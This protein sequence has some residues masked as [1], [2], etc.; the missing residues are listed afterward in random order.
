MAH[1]RSG[2]V[3]VLLV[4]A[5]LQAACRAGV[6]SPAP[7]SSPAPTR[8][9]T[10]PPT[11]TPEP[12]D[13]PTPSPTATQ[14][15]LQL[16][17]VA[18]HRIQDDRYESLPYPSL[19]YVL[20][21][22]PYTFPVEVRGTPKARVLARDGALASACT[23]VDV[24]DGSAMGFGQ[25]P[26]GETVGL[27]F[28]DCTDARGFPEWDTLTLVMDLEQSE[29]VAISTDFELTPSIVQQGVYAGVTE[30]SVV[31][32]GAYI[33]RPPLRAIAVRL[34]VRDSNGNYLGSSEAGVLGD[35]IPGG[36]A[37]IERGH[38]FRSGMR[39]VLDPAFL[40]EPLKYELVPIGIL[41]QP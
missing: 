18:W 25:V 1:N 33:G 22:N 3:F 14:P 10:L 39:I 13:T 20:L 40:N 38:R 23:G 11:S 2:L 7:T 27:Y 32:S 34:T 12:S 8:T 6:Q 9:A 41:A 5:I 36:Y 30:F 21:R 4:A 29:P 37:N 16:E 35:L 26:P 17:L 24:F 31:F 19:I 28:R 15:G